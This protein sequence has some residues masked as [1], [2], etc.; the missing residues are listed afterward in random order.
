MVPLQTDQPWLVSLWFPGGAS[1]GSPTS[2]CQGI[3]IRPE[4]ARETKTEKETEINRHRE[5][6]TKKEKILAE[7]HSQRKSERGT[8]MDGHTDTGT[9]RPRMSAS[10]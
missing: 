7:R 8:D 1:P 10:C 4:R 2:P 6:Q 3:W 5:S 9:H